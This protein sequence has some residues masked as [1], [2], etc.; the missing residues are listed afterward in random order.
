MLTARLF[1]EI[2]NRT[3]E[4]TEHTLVTWNLRWRALIKLNHKQHPAR[5]ISLSSP[6]SCAPFHSP[7]PPHL[8]PTS[9][10]YYL[11][12]SYTRSL[13]LFC[14]YPLLSPPL[15]LR[16]QQSLQPIWHRLTGPTLSWGRSIV[17]NT[18]HGSYIK[19]IRHGCKQTIYAAYSRIFT[20]RE[21]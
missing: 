20:L 19:R 11:P 1:L 6:S 18:A 10:I 12:L 7:S 3:A 5:L 4:H 21:C 13:S 8:L 17:T 9:H 16:G 15:Y 14:S 2:Q